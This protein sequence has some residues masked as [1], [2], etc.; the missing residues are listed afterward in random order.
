MAEYYSENIS[1]FILVEQ[2]SKKFDPDK[3]PNILVHLCDRQ[4]T[5]IAKAINIQF[6]HRYW[7][8]NWNPTNSML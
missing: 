8:N 4:E 1:G 5:K 2:L 3:L 7:D 6:Q